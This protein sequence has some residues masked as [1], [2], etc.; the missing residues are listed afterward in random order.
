MVS[1]Y[2]DPASLHSVRLT[3]AVVDNE[4][5]IVVGRHARQR[6][7]NAG[8]AVGLSSEAVRIPGAVHRRESDRFRVE[9]VLEE[10]IA[11]VRLKVLERRLKRHLAFFLRDGNCSGA[12]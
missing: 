8:G 5:S 3:A 12:G 10:T 7:G 2:S 6:H 4:D 9:M 11:R 1:I